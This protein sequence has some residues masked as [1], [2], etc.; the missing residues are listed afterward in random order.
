[1]AMVNAITVVPGAIGAFR[2]EA[3]ENA[4][5]FTSD[6]LAEDCDLTVRIIKAGYK[7]EDEPGAIAYTEAPESLGMFLKQRFRWS[8]GVLQTFWKHRNIFLNSDY[9]WLGC[10]AWPNVLLFQ[11]FIPLFTPLADLLM[12]I[13]LITGSA[14]RIL[15]YYLLF[16]LIDLG[17]S[18]LAFSFEKEKP[19]KL[20]LLIPQRIIY[21]WLMVYVLFKT[22]FRTMRGELQGWGLLKRSGHVR[23]KPTTT[24]L[25]STES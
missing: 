25:S 3:I 4:G 10:F 1:M 12:V 7:I 19:G 15:P 17:L 9:G 14:G 13:G 5:G 2:K 22:F 18:L 23:L 8:F 24:S 16:Q 6:T 11:F 21:R 20:I